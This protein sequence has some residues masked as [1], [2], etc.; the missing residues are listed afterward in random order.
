MGS[1]GVNKMGECGLLDPAEP[2]EVGMLHNVKMQ[3]GGDLD[4]SVYRIVD[5]FFLV[6]LV[7]VR[8]ALT[9]LI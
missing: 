7:Q 2:L 4:E 1:T 5:D 9:V 3:L 8:R 6:G